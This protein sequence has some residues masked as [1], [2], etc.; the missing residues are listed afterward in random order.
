MRQYNFLPEV[1]SRNRAPYA[2]IVIKDNYALRYVAET[3]ENQYKD[4]PNGKPAF[5][6]LYKIDEDPGERHNLLKEKSDVV[7]ELKSIWE[8]EAA[9]YPPPVAIGREKWKQIVSNRKE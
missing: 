1:P 5:Y 3:P 2:W 8:R 7:N 9:V 4:I 6:E